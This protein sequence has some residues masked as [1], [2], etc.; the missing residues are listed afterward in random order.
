MLFGYA[1]LGATWL[2]MKTEGDLQTWARLQAPRALYGVL[3]AVGG[4]QEP[5]LGEDLA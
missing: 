2:V 4:L 3:A 5:V 1:L